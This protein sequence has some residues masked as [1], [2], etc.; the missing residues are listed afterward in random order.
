[1]HAGLMQ[2][3]LTPVQL[4][5]LP[6]CEHISVTAV[7]A[8]LQQKQC[9]CCLPQYKDEYELPAQSPQVIVEVARVCVHLCP[10]SRGPSTT[11]LVFLLWHARVT[12]V[13]GCYSLVTQCIRGPLWRL[14]MSFLS[15][16]ILCPRCSFSESLRTPQRTSWRFVRPACSEHNLRAQEPASKDSCHRPQ[17]SSSTFYKLHRASGHCGH[18]VP[19]KFRPSLPVWHPQ[20]RL[21]GLCPAKRS[22]I[23]YLT[24]WT[25][26]LWQRQLQA[27][28]S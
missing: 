12:R 16:N 4:I 1:M 26:C 6:D 17:S 8:W 5:L 20:A 22:R 25:M 15:A 11:E 9:Q 27:P 21:F 10:L 2:P 3:H 24:T 13:T 28:R 19:S 7:V 23:L 18:H 14:D